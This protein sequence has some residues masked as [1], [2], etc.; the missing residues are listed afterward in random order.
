M[1]RSRYVY[2]LRSRPTGSLARVSLPVV[3]SSYLGRARYGRS[4]PTVRVRRD[5][6]AGWLLAGGWCV[7]HKPG[8]WYRPTTSDA[9]ASETAAHTHKREIGT[10]QQASKQ[11]QAQAKQASKQMQKCGAANCKS[12]AAGRESSTTQYAKWRTSTRILAATPMAILV[13]PALVLTKSITYWRSSVNRPL[14]SHLRTRQDGRMK[15][16]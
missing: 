14:S 2:L 7:A 4:T 10:D 5:D 8:G 12:W 6:L 9:R 3:E 16:A 11:A 13:V 1:C 15:V